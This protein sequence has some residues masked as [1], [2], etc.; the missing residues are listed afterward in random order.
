MLD[1]QPS[2]RR[3]AVRIARTSTTL[4]GMFL[5]RVRLSGP[6]R[7]WSRKLR[8][9][10]ATTTW[11]QFGE[12]AMSLATW[13]IDKGLE[14]GQT[15]TVIGSTRP[16]WAI[17]DMGGQLAGAVTVG[18]YSTLAPSQL[19]YLLA[20]ADTAILIVEG[21]D[22]VAKLREIR[23]EIPSVRHVL[24]WDA[25]AIPAD[26]VADGWMSAWETALTTSADPAAVDRRVEA[27]KPDD[28]AILVYT[29]GTTGP[30]K[31]AMIT[32]RNILTVLGRG[33][34]LPFD[35]DDHSL[36][37]LPMAHVAERI[38]SFY[39]RLDSG[40]STAYASSI[41]AVLGEL[42]EV[43]PTVFGSV[44]RIYE[45]AYA[46]IMAEVAKASPLRQ[47]IFRW[48]EGVGREAVRRWQA[49]RPVPLWTSLKYRLA[50]RVF[51]KIRAVFGGQVRM[52]ATGAAPIAV[53]ILEFFWAAGIRIYEVY[54]MTELTVICHANRPGSVRLGSV[55]TPLPFADA[56][57]AEDGEV[58]VRGDT[59][60]KGYY[61]NPEA[62]AEAVDAEGYMHTG[63]IGRLD[64]DGYLYIVDRK[65]HI[66]ITAGGKNLTPANI[67]QEIQGQ[68]P[69]I[70]HVHVHGDRRPYVTALVTLHP[71][72]ALEFAV[73]RDIA[74][75][76][77]AA[78]A[79]IAALMGDPLARPAGLD[80]VMATVAAHDEVRTRIA[81]ACARANAQL[82]RVEHVRRL[83][84]LGRELSLE[85]EEITPTLKRKRK[86][87]EAN[88][89]ASFDRLYDDPSFGIEV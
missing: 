36:S 42:Q 1:L 61:K 31:G 51:G 89:A 84:I 13:L 30:P 67:E 35:E 11:A 38:L 37:F 46:R 86:E 69:L 14:S 50:R 29:S 70:S 64:D 23:A 45:K 54:G 78:K 9:E 33:E 55:G 22:E 53:E 5:E 74:P 82:S 40:I 63:D 88:H 6:R 12:A 60:F 8:G 59:V 16:E 26:L 18:A 25:A 48:A 7:A 52:S 58:L 62:T 65:K 66:I 17:A 56:K 27:V 85:H 10:W 3:P 76:A 73:A 57:L 2:A 81:A 71:I 87:I 75:D 79:M 28:T 34:L 44:P 4:P 77:A 32:H 19:A 72:E 21:A 20:H 68:E 47:R 39:G 41:S 15:L 49:G 80:E 43:R 83:F 24:V